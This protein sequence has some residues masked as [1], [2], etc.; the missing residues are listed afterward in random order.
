MEPGNESPIAKLMG[1]MF[2]GLWAGLVR[3]VR[4]KSKTWQ[5]LLAEMT[6]SSFAACV[7]GGLL[8]PTGVFE[9]VDGGIPWFGFALVGVSAH[10]GVQALFILEEAVQS[11]LL[12]VIVREIKGD[13]NG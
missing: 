8:M 12:S 1:F 3:A 10:M 2:I 13:K 5:G 11:R 9:V 6:V 4:N 7:T